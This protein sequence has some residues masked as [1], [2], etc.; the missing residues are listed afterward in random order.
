MPEVT[1]FIALGE[2]A[3]ARPQGPRPHAPNPPHLIPAVQGGR[4]ALT[5][6]APAG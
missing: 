6:F 2:G 1:A 4:I 5:P 3:P